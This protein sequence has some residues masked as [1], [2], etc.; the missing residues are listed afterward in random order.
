[1]TNEI[2]LWET[3]DGMLNIRWHCSE[4]TGKMIE[5]L[6]DAEFYLESDKPIRRG[7]AS[8]SDLSTAIRRKFN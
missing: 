7:G 2:N 1:M 3:A 6:L 4:N 5:D 8:G